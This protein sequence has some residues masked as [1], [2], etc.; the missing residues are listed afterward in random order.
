MTESSKR[1]FIN[2][3]EVGYIDLMPGVKSRILAGINSGKM[4]MA[5]TTVEPGAAVPTHAHPHEQIGMV[6]SGRASFRIG[7]EVREV[8]RNDFFSIP[9]NVDHE[10]TCISAEPFIAIDIFFPIREDMAEK[11]RKLESTGEAEQD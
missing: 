3:D 4:M 11:A 7:D 9:P 1:Y 5:L 10:A 2:P 6:F 8:S